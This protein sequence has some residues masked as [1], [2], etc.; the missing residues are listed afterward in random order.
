MLALTAGL[1]VAQDQP[2]AQGGDDPWAA[3][4][5]D[6][7]DDAWADP[8]TKAGL[9]WSGFAEG[10]AGSRWNRDP[11]VGRKTTL[12]DL[13]LRLETQWSGEQL[14]L[15]LKADGLYDG[16]DENLTGDFRELAI[17]G[18]LATSLDAK[19]GRQV[20]TWGTGDLVFLN[21][22]FPKDWVSFFAG[23]ED[24]YLK[25]PSNTLRLTQ[26]NGVLNI[27]FAWTP[28]FTPDNYLNGDRFSF[29][30]PAAGTVVAPNP[31]LGAEKPDTD[32][33][34]G[35]FALRL[36]RTI[37]GVEYALYGYRGYFKQ[38]SD[39]RVAANPRF[40]PMDSLGA[41]I[42]RPAWAGLWNVEA[43][44]Y[45]SR[46]DRSGNNPAIP[47]DQ[48]RFLTGFEREWLTNFTVGLQYYLEWIQ[49]Y[50]AQVRNSATP[51]YEPDEYRH[52]LT[53]RLTYRAMQEK[54]IWSLFGFVSPSD[55]DYYLRPV[56]NYRYSDAWNFTAGLN[57]FGGDKNYSFFGQ[58][59][60][61]SNAY[62]R[63][64]RN[65]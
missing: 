44:Y 17:A 24:E 19:A 60:D 22:L 47:N 16:Y 43:A 62:L 28:K 30:S 5:D 26:Y 63:V 18:S 33:S 11:A 50:D 15:S 7:W 35:E 65:F 36:F 27:D 64:R 25:A 61:N 49:D 58:F 51:Q 41:S 31:P 20:L 21:D 59:E 57:L 34:N 45:F 56:L 54:L 39:F 12:A 10:A 38:P 23:R 8:E 6:S 53:A 29:F 13:R 48:V 46:D 1:A 9:A 32:F 37:R 52:L 14:T 42:R 2:A 55:Q 4:A 40:A 3:T